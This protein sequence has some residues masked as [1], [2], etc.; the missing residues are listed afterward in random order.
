MGASRSAIEQA[1]GKPSSVR[2]ATMQDVFGKRAN[3]PDKKTGQVDLSYTD[4]GLTLS[5]HDNAL[6][7][8][9]IRAPRPPVAVP[10]DAVAK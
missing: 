3:D 10:K 2:E 8:I 7:S 5:L 1:Y 9:M 4:L 6:D